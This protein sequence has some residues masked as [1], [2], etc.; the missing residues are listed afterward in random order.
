MKHLT[1]IVAI[2]IACCLHLAPSLCG[3]EYGI[4]LLANGS[5][6][7]T[8]A[9]V[10][11]NDIATA[12]VGD[13]KEHFDLKK[14]QWQDETTGKWVTFAQCE[15]WAAQSKKKSALSSAT[16]PPQVRA[17]V[18]WSLNPTY[19]TKSTKT[20]L[21]LTSGQV[22]YR[23]TGT[24]SE[25]DLSNYF[26]YAKL[27]AYKKAMTERKLPPFAELEAIS[28]MERHGIVPTSITVEMPG[29]PRA[30]RIKMEIDYK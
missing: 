13:S 9:L 26:K 28:A 18:A 20:S 25:R 30:P 7:A 29:V 14:N 12:T 5:E 27:N 17:F 16:V 3:E 24:K 1:S 2:A 8:I 19:E 22:D 11:E 4:K 6:I 23:I 15:D 21:V 10:I